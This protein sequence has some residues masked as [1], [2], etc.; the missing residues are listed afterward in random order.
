MLEREFQF[1]R[2]IVDSMPAALLSLPDD[3]AK[4]R[5]AHEAMAADLALN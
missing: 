1:T 5:L 3:L 4:L 2:R